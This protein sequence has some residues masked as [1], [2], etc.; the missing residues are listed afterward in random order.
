M[1]LRNYI[2]RRLSLLI[3]VILGVLVLVFI[4]SYVIPAD[5]ARAWAG[6]KAR[7]EQIE[8]LRERYHLNDPVYMQI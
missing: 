7:P 5:P 8:A 3:P 1:R 4:I 6:P 2:I